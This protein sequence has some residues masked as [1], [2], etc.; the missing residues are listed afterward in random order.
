MVVLLVVAALYVTISFGDPGYVLTGPSAFSPE[1]ATLASMAVPLMLQTCEQ[2]GVPKPPRAK[3]CYDCGRCVRRMDHHCWWLGN[4][5]GEETHR[6]FLFYLTAQS[7]LLWWTC[8]CAVCGVVGD[9]QGKGRGPVPSGIAIVAG[10]LCGLVTLLIGL[11]ALTLLIFQVRRPRAHARIAPPA[12]ARR[13]PARRLP[14]L[15]PLRAHWSPASA[16]WQPCSGGIMTRARES[17]AAPRESPA[18][19]PPPAPS[20]LTPLGAA[21]RQCVLLLRGET[22][23]EHLRREQLNHSANLPPQLRPYARRPSSL[24]HPL[25]RRRPRQSRHHFLGAITSA[26][27][28]V[29]PSTV[30]ASTPTSHPAPGTTAAPCAT[31]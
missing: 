8:V 12:T 1:P 25:H 18:V 17:R 13:E 23:W 19:P 7:V 3:H 22:T 6:L 24:R 26:I 28:W 16:A 11:A 27:F 30:S 5:V 21:R 20:S 14:R 10:V 31:S 9:A 29:I 15:P 2:C 4:C